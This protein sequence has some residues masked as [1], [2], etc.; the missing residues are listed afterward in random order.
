LVLWIAIEAF[1]RVTP[2]AAV[3]GSELPAF[4]EF[5][6]A[7]GKSKNKTDYTD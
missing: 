6:A 3:A 4:G 5:L 1:F 7:D 2:S